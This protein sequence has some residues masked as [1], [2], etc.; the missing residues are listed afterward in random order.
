MS[1]DQTS[2]Y[3]INVSSVVERWTLNWCDSIF[4]V[5]VLFGSF[6]SGPKINTF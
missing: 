3:E 2:K 6:G 4:F 5:F 1:Y